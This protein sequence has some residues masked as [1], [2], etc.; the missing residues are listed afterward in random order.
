MGK[1]LLKQQVYFMKKISLNVVVESINKNYL[2][3][4]FLFWESKFFP[5]HRWHFALH[6]DD[7]KN[8]FCTRA[9]DNGRAIRTPH[10]NSQ[11]GEYF[12]FRLGVANGEAITMED[13]K[14][15]GRI[16]IDFYKIDEENYYMDFS[17]HT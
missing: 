4:P 11:I 3:L 12:R 8:L 5:D 10:N 13:F 6:T 1:T 2:Y 7:E 14:R 17:V 15:Y 9:Q 16:D